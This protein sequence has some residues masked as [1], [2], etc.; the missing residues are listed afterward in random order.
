[1]TDVTL[2][3]GGPP[4][5]IKGHV[6]VC[7]V[8]LR[9]RPQGRKSE[10][11]TEANTSSTITKHA[12]WR[13]SAPE[14]WRAGLGGPHAHP[15]LPRCC[16]GIFTAGTGLW[17]DASAPGLKVTFSLWPAAISPCSSPGEPGPCCATNGGKGQRRRVLQ[18]QLQRSV[19]SH[20]QVG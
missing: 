7:R 3:T 13:L 12:V 8:T 6:I 18:E 10:G 11:R 16:W 9:V 20:S 5:P 1:M 2:P 19:S 17:A 15:R 14:R 4:H